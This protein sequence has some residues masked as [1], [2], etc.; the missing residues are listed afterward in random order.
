[1]NQLKFR[2][3]MLLALFL[4]L[5]VVPGAFAPVAAQSPNPQ[6]AAFTANASGVGEAALAAR[7]AR[8]PVSWAVTN[9]PENANLV[10]EQILSSGTVVNVELPRDFVIVP[11][12]GD[13]V[14]A[15]LPPGG[16]ADVVRIQLRLIDL[17]NGFEYARRELSIAIT[18]E[19]VEEPN[20]IFFDTPVT[21]V[22]QAALANQTER[23]Q[24]SWSIENR[25]PNSNL[26]FEQFIPGTDTPVNVE[27]PRT[28][29]IVPSAG[30]GVVAPLLPGDD[31]DE[32][33]LQLRL[34]DLSRPSVYDMAEIRLPIDDTPANQPA[35]STFSTPD[36][37][38]DSLALQV[39]A[40]RLP[41]SFAVV[42]RPANS[43]L[44]FD[45][46]LTDG[47]VVNVELPRE[48]PIVP[49]SGAGV[50]APVPPGGDA[51]EIT[52]RL[53]L[54][55]LATGS[56]YAEE[57][58]ALP[59]EET[60]GPEPAIT[61]FST[62]ATEVD[63]NQLIAG[64]AR[65]PVAWD[66][67]G[68]PSG[69][70]LVFEQVLP[71][72]SVVNIELPR[73]VLVIP[74]SGTNGVV[75]PRDP[76]AGVE[77]IELQLRLWDMATGFEYDVETLTLPI[78]T[79]TGPGDARINSF[80]L[81]AESVPAAALGN[82]TARVNLNWTTIN[83]PANSNLFFEQVLPGGTVV[84]VE[85]PRTDPIIPS[86]GTGVIAPLLPGEGA[87]SIVIQVR[88]ANLTT[89]ALIDR[90][91]RTL[92]ITGLSEIDGTM[93][94]IDSFTVTPQAAAPGDDVTL[95]WRVSGST[96]VRIFA[97]AEDGSTQQAEVS[98]VTSQAGSVVYTIPETFVSSAPFRLVAENANGR[99][100]QQEVTVTLSGEDNG[101]T[102]EN[103]GDDNGGEEMACALTPE[104]LTDECPDNQLVTDIAFQTFQ[105]G[106]MVWRND[107][108]VIYVLYSAGGYDSV[109]DLWTP[110]EV[111]TV[112][113]TPPDG[114]LAPERGF[115]KVWVDNLA[116]RDGLGWA[117]SAEAGASSTIEVYGSDIY[118]Q[119]PNGEVLILGDSQW[120]YQP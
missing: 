8:I 27:L 102:G 56:V 66:T 87:T 86:S 41:V 12:S 15:P 120:Q 3:V 38:V 2:R 1:M 57:T 37:S 74:S 115:G 59:I 53:Q 34:V 30:V 26:I 69:S 68:R 97:L 113:E 23:V 117:T 4:A 112:D 49:S 21:V 95:A 16:D 43:N 106:A 33:I 14:V 54:V 47:S 45:Q 100:A 31:A 25:P 61:Q 55:D 78:R 9:R 7:T 35:I 89:G 51:E 107:L 101:E 109:T 96:S 92:P 98:G 40:V 73:D 105:N 91:E 99:S 119:L 13:G 85:L 36:D 24:V 17:G 39:G 80:N 28:E 116:I 5:L 111:I 46:V 76:G 88:L 90:V 83:R 6:I 108:G 82:R 94:T 114:L 63:R 50:V 58:I 72:G 18:E 67:E 20:I 29:P 77:T 42:N 71:D 84:N 81:L 104:Y 110:D 64:T 48:E 118:M 11:S 10:F 93:P 22:S 60:T 32:I 75:A 103:G 52:L 44:V 65:V 70:N 79:S 62:T 19:P